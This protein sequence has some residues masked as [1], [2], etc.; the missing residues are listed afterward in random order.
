MGP[1][2]I[3]VL[4]WCHQTMKIYGSHVTALRAFFW[5]PD[6]PKVIAM[7]ILQKELGWKFNKTSDQSMS[8]DHDDETGALR[9]DSLDTRGSHHQVALG[10]IEE[11]EGPKS[12]AD[13]GE[14]AFGGLPDGGP[15]Y[16]WNTN[17]DPAAETALSQYKKTVMP[18]KPIQGPLE[19]KLHSRSSK[20][21]CTNPNAIGHAHKSLVALHLA[22]LREWTDYWNSHNMEIPRPIPPSYMV[23]VQGNQGT[24]NTF[25]TCTTR[26]MTRIVI[27]A[28]YYDMVTVTT[29]V[30]A[31]LICGETHI[32]GYIIPT[33]EEGICS[34]F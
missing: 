24:G 9:V 2:F 4:A 23:K 20:V 26:N 22:A 34:S 5:S 28:V 13:L 14:D 10:I 12:D 29:G 27:C 30:A 1:N 19:T 31:D 18:F 6:C 16:V 17:Y 15:D 33:K 25:I 7:S 8:R 3:S 32:R 11:E 21:M